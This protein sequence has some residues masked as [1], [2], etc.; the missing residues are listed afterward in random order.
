MSTSVN[1]INSRGLPGLLK[2]GRFAGKNV[3]VTGAGSGIGYGIVQAFANE[4]ATVALNDLNTELA[5]QATNEINRALDNSNVH[6]YPGDVANPNTVQQLMHRFKDH[7][8]VPDIVIANAGITQYVE[9]LECTPAMF[10]RVVQVNLRGSYFLAQMAAK[11]MIA[12]NQP[13]RIILMS[14]V[15]GQR[16]FLNFSVYSMTKAALPMLAKAI[17]LE[18]GQYGITVN[19]IAPGATLTERT[20]REDPNYAENWAKVAPNQRVGTVEDIANAALFL[21]SPQA[22]HITGQN[23]VVDG[24]WTMQSPRPEDHPEMPEE[25]ES[26]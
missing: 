25:N 19:S 3:I 23:L 2:Q 22:T 26:V 8:G 5:Q 13:G 16:A 4:G 15:V 24:G 18:L 1:N 21:A 17:A 7:I 12:A 9:F 20:L 14:S 11:Q 10:D 6:A